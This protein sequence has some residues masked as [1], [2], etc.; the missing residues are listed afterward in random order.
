MLTMMTARSSCFTDRRLTPIQA[1]CHVALGQGVGRARGILQPV[2]RILIFPHLSTTAQ[3]TNPA[4]S[5]GKTENY[6]LRRGKV[7]NSS[8]RLRLPSPG[9]LTLPGC[10]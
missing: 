1:A 5:L 2:F 10:T 6:E 8:H 9:T 7:P 4:N 3:H